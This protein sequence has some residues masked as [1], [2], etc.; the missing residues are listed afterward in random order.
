RARRLG[1]R[2]GVR[3]PGA[4]G[5]AEPVR[6]RV[7]LHGHRAAAGRRCW[8]GHRARGAEPAGGEAGAGRVGRPVGRGRM[9][10]TA[11]GHFDRATAVAADGSVEIDPAYGGFV[12]AHGGYVAAIALRA[13]ADVIGDVEREP[14]S[15]TI[16]LLAPIA[17][18]PLQVT[19]QPSR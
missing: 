14:R 10:A 12:G 17:I 9:S 6:R 11:G 15:L 16:Q 18:G 2:R 7:D 1:P 5:R 13:L 4:A 19:T 3:Q 8:A